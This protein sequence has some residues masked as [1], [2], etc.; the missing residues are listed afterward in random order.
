MKLHAYINIHNLIFIFAIFYVWIKEYYEFL[1]PHSENLN[2][3]I[4]RVNRFEYS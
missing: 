4:T 2:F 3:F 1:L